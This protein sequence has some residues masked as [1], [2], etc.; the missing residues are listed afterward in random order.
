[1][2]Q[3]SSHKPASLLPVGTRRCFSS[4]R[5][6]TLLQQAP[7]T[8]RQFNPHLNYRFIRDNTDLVQRNARNRN[9]H[10]LDV[11]KTAAL[12]ERYVAANHALGELRSRR[13]AIAGSMAKVV[14]ELKGAD[15][16]AR[17]ALAGAR[18]RL[19]DEGRRMKARVAEDEHEVAA[20]KAEL[21]EEAR[22]IPNDT[23]PSSPIGDESKAICLST[24]HVPRPATFP[25]GSPL[26]DHMELATL[27][28]MVDF[29]RAGKVAGSSFYYLRN[30]GAMLEMA[31]ARYA[32]DRCIGQGFVPMITPDVIRHEVLEACGFNPRSEDPQTYYIAPAASA[33]A[34]VS[35]DSSRDPMQ[36]CLTATAEF[37]LAAA[38]ANEVLPSSVLPIKQVASS[39]AFRAEGL[40]GATNRGLY[41]VHQ[42]T[43]IEMFALT[44]PRESEAVLAQMVDIQKSLY[45]D[46]GICFRELEMP[47]HDLGAPAY[48][49]I[50]LEAWMPGRKAWGEISSASSCTDYQSRRLDIRYFPPATSGSE[51]AGGRAAVTDFVHTV[52]GTACAVPRLIIALLETHQLENGDVAIPEVLRPYLWNAEV[53]KVGVSVKDLMQGRSK[54]S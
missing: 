9:V 31:L 25:S 18:S 40:A 50:D 35:T 2:L 42:F 47:T 11:G 52:N 49:K 28:D 1:M 17:A 16:S 43:K 4:S 26:R 19:A 45:R 54:H 36:L 3:R 5:S 27:H 46:L 14:A 34:P 44:A 13:N 37:P 8:A 7:P 33:S 20:L 41:R 51:P 21:Y 30:M 39:H 6:R 29:E 15:A 10:D 53:I 12:Y 48:R 38:H 24:T 23:H 32:M 22:H